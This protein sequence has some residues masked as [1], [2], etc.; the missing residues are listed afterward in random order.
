MRDH[1][2]PLWEKL[3]NLQSHC[4]ERRNTYKYEKD[5]RMVAQFLR[6][7]YKL[8]DDFTDEEILRVCGIIEVSVLY[9]ILFYFGQ[10]SNSTLLK[11]I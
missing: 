4:A 8:E 9:V 6:R 2:K 5:K 3:K 10:S 11:I 1:N 7:F